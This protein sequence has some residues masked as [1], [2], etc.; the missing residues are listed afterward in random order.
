M[1]KDYL[2]KSID[3]AD[4]AYKAGDKVVKNGIKEAIDAADKVYNTGDKNVKGGLKEA[5]KIALRESDVDTLEKLGNMWKEGL[6][7]DD[8][9]K[10]AKSRLLGRI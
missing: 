3:T 1:I 10:I 8:E 6:L 5:K 2:K 9:Y 7:T 4:K